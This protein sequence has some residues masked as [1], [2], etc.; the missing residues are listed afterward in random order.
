MSKLDENLLVYT[1]I[2]PTNKLIDK[3]KISALLCLDGSYVMPSFEIK[4][5]DNGEIL[6]SWDNET[7]LKDM[8]EMFQRYSNNTLTKEDLKFIKELEE[9]IPQ[10]NFETVILLF[11]KAVQLKM[12]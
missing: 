3:Y 5:E 7:Y 10:E 4:N 1:T 11:N 8:Y 6:E 12:F 2:E 9:F